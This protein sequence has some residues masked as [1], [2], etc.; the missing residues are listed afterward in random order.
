MIKYFTRA[1]KITNENIIL[2]TPLVLS[3]FLLSVYLGIAKNAPETWPSIILL[4]ITTIFM[5]S[6]FFAGWFFMVKRA[7]D[8]GREEFAADEDKAR[9]SFNLLKELPVGIGE[10]FFSFVGGLILYAALFL[11]LSFIGYEIGLHFIGKV[12]IGFG[13]FK[14]AI[15]SSTAMKTLVSSLSVE[16][17]AKLN[18]WNLLFLTTMAIFSFITL[19]WGAHIIIKNKNPFV[20]FFQ[21]LNF[22]FKNFSSSIILF[23]YISIINFAIS[24]IN[25]VSTLNPIIYFMSMLIYFYFVV[26]VVVLIFLYYDSESREN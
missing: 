20:A 16:Q 25:A 2:A 13:E 11:L 4:L 14:A 23:F 10:Y 8:I 12:G 9:A 3:L 18:A 26:Y 19:F 17:L 24:F 7:I 21:A 5:L 1:F 6:A 15:S 22:T